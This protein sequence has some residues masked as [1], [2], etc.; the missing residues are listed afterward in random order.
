MTFY[1]DISKYYDSIFKVSKDSIE[2]IKDALGTSRKTVLDVAC[3]TGGHALELEKSGYDITAV[4]LDKEMIKRLSEKATNS[5]SGISF[6]NSDMMML[7]EKFEY[8]S[9]EAVYCIGNSLVHLEGLSQIEKYFN[10]IRNLLSNDGVMIFQII[11][12]DRVI[13]KGV[14]SLPT[15]VN[16]SVNLTFERNY[17]YESSRDKVVFQTVLTVPE[18]IIKN[19]IDLI[20]LKYDEVVKLLEKTGFEDI[21][22]YGNFKKDSFEKDLSYS[23]VVKARVVK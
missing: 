9:F 13:S 2:F 14:K 3:G 23:M 15:I 5:G 20:P 22:V 17:R 1:D 18:G 6:L 21:D 12:Y 16:K 4:D 11:N 10:D 19:E 8:G 7:A